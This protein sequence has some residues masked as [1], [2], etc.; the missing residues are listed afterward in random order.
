M[1]SFSKQNFTTVHRNRQERL[2]AS[3]AEAT[4]TFRLS[5]LTAS[6]GLPSDRARA[7]T[8]AG[9]RFT[10]LFLA[11]RDNSDACLLHA[12][13]LGWPRPYQGVYRC[14]ADSTSDPH[15]FVPT[16]DDRNSPR[17]LAPIGSFPGE[18]HHCRPPSRPGHSQ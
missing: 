14:S 18:F 11:A 17:G 6:A 9:P 1:N 13:C 8:Q 10:S 7:T 16:S 15:L 5:Y 12:S 2:R 4:T 3:G